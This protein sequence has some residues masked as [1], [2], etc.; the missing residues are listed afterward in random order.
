MEE[1]RAKYYIAR[2]KST[3]GDFCFSCWVS[4][5]IRERLDRIVEKEGITRSI[6][7]RAALLAFLDAYEKEE[8][9]TAENESFV[10][11]R[12]KNR[13]YRGG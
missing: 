3:T 2:E 7:I 12:R 5:E 4:K 13:K 9:R 8:R 11:C 6:A 1:L 10:P